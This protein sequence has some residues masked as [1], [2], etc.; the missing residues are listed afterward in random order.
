MMAE[1]QQSEQL[2]PLLTFTEAMDMA[3]GE[4]REKVLKVVNLSTFFLFCLSLSLLYLTR[5]D[6]YVFYLVAGFILVVAAF[7]GV[8]NW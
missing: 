2:S 3:V 1:Q 4:T 6:P 5:K 8:F 7:A